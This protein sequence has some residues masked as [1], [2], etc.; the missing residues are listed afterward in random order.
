MAARWYRN[1]QLS[2]WLLLLACLGGVVG[3]LFTAR[4]MVAL[5]PVAAVVAAG[6][7]P[8][9]HR[10]VPQ[11]L[12]NRGAQRLAALYVLMPLSWWYTQDWPVWRHEVYRQ[13]PLIGVPLA[14]CLA[15]PLSRRQRLGIGVFFVG[16]T[17]LLGAATVGRYLLDPQAAQGL[18]RVGQNVPSVSG[19]FHIH[20]GI[21]L[22][23]AAF[24]A[25]PLSRLPQ[26][27]KG[28]RWLLL[29]AGAVAVVSL[30]ILAYRTGLLAFYSALVSVV[31]LLLRRRPLLALGVVAL[32]VM[33]AFGAYHSLASVQERVS[34]TFYDLEQYQLGHD[35]NHFSLSRR[36]AAWHNALEIVG[37]HPWMGVAPADVRQELMAQ[38]AVRTYGLAPE[39][40]VMVHNQYLHYLVGGG[41]VGLAVWLWVLIQPLVQPSLRRNPYVRYFLLT[42]G[43]AALA[44]SLLELQIGFNL[45]VFLY[46][47]LVV[48]AERRAQQ[49]GATL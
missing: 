27:S 1:G 47:F 49:P 38:F 16:T 33:L 23:L 9:I 43:A 48:A 46:G 34:S 21:L 11:W 25:V 12:R 42:F 28:P 39:N 17:A 8:N 10:E 36:L 31:L 15:V 29:I 24:F 19:I 3:L 41:V 45:F 18:I 30:H 4:A 14:F 22:A 13:L 35:I 7:N 2:Q 20:F 5:A 40:R 32:G 6:L 26:L 37:R 44:D